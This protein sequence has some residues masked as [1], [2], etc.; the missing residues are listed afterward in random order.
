M[1]DPMFSIIIPC[2]NQARYLPDCLESILSQSFQSWEVLVIN[3]GSTDDTT[4]VARNYIEKDQRIKLIEKLNGG[5]SSA[6][7]A[8][9]RAAS[10]NR[11]LFL[12]AD[13]FLNDGCLKAI[14]DAAV[15]CDDATLIQYGYT[16]ITEDK[17]YILHSA[18]PAIKSS[19][20]PSILSAPP[21]PC[22]SICISK[23]LALQ[24]GEFDEQLKSL[25]DWDYWLRAAKAGATQFVIDQHLVYYRYVRFSM[26]RNP[27]VML[28]AIKT[29]AA[30]AGIKDHRVLIESPCNHDRTF[31][32]GSVIQKS[33]IR[34]TGVGIMQNKLKESLEFYQAESI[35]PLRDCSVKELEDM[36]SY[37]S[38]RY[39]YRKKDVE[40]ILT[41]IKPLFISFFEMAGFEKKQNQKAVFFIFSR[42]LFYQNNYRYGKLLGS[43]M[44][45]FLRKKYG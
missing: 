10:G 24:I 38:F 20:F 4:S 31:D 11:Y 3:D 22:H 21:G 44:N 23:N 37:L 16:Y 42:H 28:D 27:F 6:R 19:Y 36:C 35:K 34:L 29:V 45:Y 12:D 43:V 18:L 17:S 14:A 8:G 30:R 7:N 32:A 41:Q 26:S 33:L 1:A 9:L 40:E 5:L 2:Y 39:W 13:D 25:E 15:I